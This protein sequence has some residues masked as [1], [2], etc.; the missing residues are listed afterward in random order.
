MDRWDDTRCSACGDL[1]QYRTDMYFEHKP[2]PGLEYLCGHCKHVTEL[3]ANTITLATRCADTEHQARR[4]SAA[5]WCEVIPVLET[6]NSPEKHFLCAEHAWKWRR[7]LGTEWEMR[8]QSLQANGQEAGEI[9]RFQRDDL[10]GAF[11]GDEST[12][13]N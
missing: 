13:I 6:N 11:W 10:A 7:D 12:E 5:C 2:A 8:A 3:P 1:A 9:F 4:R